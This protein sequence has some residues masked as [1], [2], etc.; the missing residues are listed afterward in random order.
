VKSKDFHKAFE[1]RQSIDYRIIKPVPTEQANLIWQK[2][3]H[4]VQAVQ[5]YFS[6]EIDHSE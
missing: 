3:A 6:R 4:F 2:A 5:H 1:L